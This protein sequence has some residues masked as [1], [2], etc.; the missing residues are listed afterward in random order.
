MGF[1]DGEIKKNA[2]RPNTVGNNAPL[3]PEHTYNLGL[4]YETS[5]SV[6]YDLVLRM[7]YMEVGETWF[8]TVQD[9]QQPAVWTALL[10]FPV[11][12]DMTRSVRDPYELIDFRASLIGEKLSL[13]LWGRNI[14]DEEYLAEVIPAPEF[15]GSFIHEAPYATYGIDLKYNF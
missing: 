10:G 3:A 11:A 15:G 9:D 13:T 2:H 7:D 6:N 12:S 5:F 14:T 4:Q 8:H 1:T